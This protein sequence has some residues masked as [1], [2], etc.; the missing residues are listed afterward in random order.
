MQDL[1]S[2]IQLRKVA[3]EASKEGFEPIRF[4]VHE[5][6][7]E[8]YLAYLKEAAPFSLSENPPML[9]D[10]GITRVTKEYP[11]HPV[12]LLSVPRKK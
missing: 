9:N 10:F 3:S 12:T 5:S 7:Y 8:E 4:L 1:P 2:P 11:G 6:V